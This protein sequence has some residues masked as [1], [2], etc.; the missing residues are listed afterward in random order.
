MAF[1]DKLAFEIIMI[2]DALGHK[3]TN[4]SLFLLI[5]ADTKA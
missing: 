1:F 4:Q 3:Q 2:V 5:V